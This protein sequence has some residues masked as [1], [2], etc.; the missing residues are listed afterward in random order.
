[1]TVALVMNDDDGTRVNYTCNALVACKILP[2]VFLSH[3]TCA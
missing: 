1:M 2:E 3:I